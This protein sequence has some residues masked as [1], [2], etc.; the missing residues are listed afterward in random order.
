MIAELVQPG[1]RQQRRLAALEHVDEL[2]ARQA[3]R[4]LGD[5]ALRGRRLDEDH[6]GT[7]FKIGG[8]ALERALEPLHGDCVGARDHHEIGIVQR[9]AHGAQLLRHLG[10][11]HERLVVVVA[12]LLGKGLILEVERRNAGALEG[13]GGALRIKRVAVAGIGIGDDRDADDVD[14]SGKPRDDLVRRDQADVRYAAGPRD[15]AAARVH[16]GKPGLLDEARGE[17]VE[18]PRGDDGLLRPQQGPQPGRRPHQLLSM[19]QNAARIVLIY[20]PGIAG[21]TPL[22][23]SKGFLMFVLPKLPDPRPPAAAM[24]G[25]RLNPPASRSLGIVDR[26]ARNRRTG[27]SWAPVTTPPSTAS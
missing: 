5:L 15:G 10:R 8:R 23:E 3:A 25:K 19:S 17:P 7:G 27:H 24:I 9:I 12:A 18:R 13:A 21:A 22:V 1:D 11:R 14:H 6:V 16:R 4:D 20:R 2:P 26:T